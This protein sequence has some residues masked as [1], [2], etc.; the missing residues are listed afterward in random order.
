[1]SLFQVASVLGIG[2]KSVH[3]LELRQKMNRT[4]QI[5]RP[6]K[7]IFKGQFNASHPP[8]MKSHPTLSLGA[9]LVLVVIQDIPMAT[10]G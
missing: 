7:P 1:M 9:T 2:E 5:P 6:V 10:D 8:L 4:N 3:P